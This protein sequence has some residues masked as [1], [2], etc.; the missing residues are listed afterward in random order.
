M[1]AKLE[2]KMAASLICVG[3]ILCWIGLQFDLFETT[4]YHVLDKKAALAAVF[5]PYALFMCYR[6]VRYTFALY[7]SHA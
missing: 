6:L 3:L 1:N 5:V 2:L 4:I 7:K